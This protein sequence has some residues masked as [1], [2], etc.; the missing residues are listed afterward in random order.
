M[1]TE[2][3]TN[4]LIIGDIILD[5]YIQ[6]KINKIAN[7][8][9]IPVFSYSDKKYILGGC[10]NVYQNMKLFN[11]KL[12]IISVVGNDNN[13]MI[14]KNMINNNDIIIDDCRKSTV[15][16]RI[17]SDNK[18]LLRYDNEDTFLINS[19]IEEMIINKFDMI[20]DKI[21]IVVF[22][23]YNKGVLTQSICQYI[24]NKCN[25]YNK[26]TIGDLKHNFNY[27]TNITLTKPNLLEAMNYTK[28]KKL[29]EIHKHII[30]T[31]KCKYSIVTMGKEGIS[32]YENNKLY[33]T[34]Y[35]SEE[36]IDVTGAGDIVTSVIGSLYNKTDIKTILTIATYLGTLSVKKSG[37]YC[38]NYIDILSA[39]SYINNKDLTCDIIYYLKKSKS[40]IVFT[41]GCFDILHIGHIQYLEQA[42]KLGDYMIVGINSDDSVSRLKGPTRPI[43]NIYDRINFL[44]R[45]DFIDYIVEFNQDTPLELI[46]LLEPDI[47]VKGGDYT[48]DTVVGREYAK[49]VVILPFVEGKSTTNIINKIL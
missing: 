17:V 12:Y 33:K 21:D 49:Q 39:Y 9:P 18:I 23:D 3:N 27:F 34:A 30:E 31:I 26:I 29:I 36:I 35:L 42:R 8:A 28:K 4:I 19:S 22:S 32:F 6:V 7:E 15:K 44:K 38:L 47:L 16:T 11:N 37:T 13:G 41:N 14:I 10:G 25:Q 2:N 20:F 1:I 48:H 5:E 40:K 46:K 43:N 45:F 24:I